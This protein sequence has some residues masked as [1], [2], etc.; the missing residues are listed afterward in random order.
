M[1]RLRHITLVALFL[2]GLRV[3]ARGDVAADTDTAASSLW[4]RTP[5]VIG[6]PGRLDG[7]GDLRYPRR[8]QRADSLVGAYVDI[9][10]VDD[11]TW[12]QHEV[13]HYARRAVDCAGTV[14]SWCRREIRHLAAGRVIFLMAGLHAELVWVSRENV[15]VRLGWQRVVVVPTGSMTVDAPPSDFAA[16]LLS[17]FSSQL[18]A[19]DF[20]AQREAFWAHREADRL[21]YYA[22][23]V[24][25]AL[26]GVGA[27]SHRRHA[28][29]FVEDN[30]AR[31]A[32]IA[33]AADTGPSDDLDAAVDDAEELPLPLARR[34]AAIRA[35]RLSTAAAPWCAAQLSSSA[36]VDPTAR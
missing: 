23:E 10:E 26:P 15:A 2:C 5:F 36:A 24:I 17:E 6:A 11:P 14:E 32:A 18:G 20:N 29:R 22:D 33:P 35:S 30:L 19:F 16:A 12:L 27:G 28:L 34:L 13:E 31:I 8:Y 9:E 3:P 7:D 25:A 21:L 4:R 1:R